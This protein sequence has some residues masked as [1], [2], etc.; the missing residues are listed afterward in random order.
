M[1]FATLP[2]AE[3]S[4]LRWALPHEPAQPAET[5]AEAVD[6]EAAGSPLPWRRPDPDDIPPERPGPS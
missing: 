3:E 4:Y 6:N 5:P 2:V 1:L